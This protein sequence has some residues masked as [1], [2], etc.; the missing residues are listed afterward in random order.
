MRRN[1]DRVD[2]SYKAEKNTTQFMGISLNLLKWRDVEGE[3]FLSLNEILGQ[4]IEYK[5]CITK[6]YA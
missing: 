4:V 1:S 2:E 5:N 3:E 6:G